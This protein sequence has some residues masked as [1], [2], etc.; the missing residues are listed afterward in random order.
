M[1][2]ESD[3]DPGSENLHLQVLKQ[4]FNGFLATPHKILCFTQD[5]KEI[6]VNRSVFLLLSPLLRSIISDIPSCILPTLFLPDISASSLMKLTD[7]LQTGFSDSFHTLTEMKSVLEAATMLNIPMQ[8]LCFGGDGSK[9]SVVCNNGTRVETATT[10]D[11]N[12]NIIKEISPRVSNSNVDK[13]VDGMAAPGEKD[14]PEQTD[15]E[16]NE[17]E[18]KDESNLPQMNQDTEKYKCEICGKDFTNIKLLRYHYC[19]HFSG[20]LEKKLDMFLDNKR[21]PCLKTFANIQNQLL[22]IGAY[23][24]IID[25]ILKMEGIDVPSSGPTLLYS[26]ARK[27]SLQLWLGV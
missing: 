5:R 21:F 7:I 2:S 6:A 20:L 18:P 15:N 10:S 12:G 17:E 8:G 11:T 1:S 3:T 27:Y 22:H 4:A 9:E 16:E 13:K 25:E 14:I 24:G 23:H 26:K 19:L